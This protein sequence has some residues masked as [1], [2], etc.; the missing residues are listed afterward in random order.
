MHKHLSCDA[1]P[2]NGQGNVAEEGSEDGDDDD[3]DN[4]DEEAGQEV[5]GGPSMPVLHL[6][7]A[8][9][10]EGSSGV[11]QPGLI[12]PWVLCLLALADASVAGMC[13]TPSKSKVKQP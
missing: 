3:D 1:G 5:R 10:K 6:A 13:N 8:G 9:H 12:S 11:L 2:H 7:E 4:D